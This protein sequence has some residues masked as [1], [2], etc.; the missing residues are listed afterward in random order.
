MKQRLFLL[1]GV[2]AVMA[3]SNTVVPV[4]PLLA[5]GTALQGAVYS[6]YFF[7]AMLTV[8]PAGILSDY[9]GR[10]L[11]L[12]AGLALTF[13]S[14]VLMLVVSDPAALIAI[15]FVE[16]IAAGLFV[17]AAMSW[18]NLQPDRER[19][20]GNFIAALNLGLVSGLV[21]AGW[22]AAPAG[23]LGGV[24]AFTAFTAVPLLM[25]AFVGEAV[26]PKRERGDP[27]GVGKDFFWLYLS[28]IVL[29]G[30]TGAV[31]AI[32]PDFT[33]ESAATLGLQ[34]GLMNVATIVTSLAASRLRLAPIP[35]IRVSAVLMAAAV[36]LLFFTPAAFMLIGGIAGVV[37]IAQINYLAT[38]P[39]RQG[40]I[41]GIFN[42]SSYGG[43]TL[44]PFMAGVVAENQGFSA[45]FALIAILAALMA[46]TIGQCR[47]RPEP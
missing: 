32:Y 15:R 23:M 5:E 8:I 34:L 7:G 2:F 30:A 11:L 20:S 12:R 31:S 28:T 4:L 38:D 37:M 35:T 18:I 3:L 40:T 10:V 29:V 17:P 14:G 1:L 42:A 19:M 16:G 21:V 6:A 22:L 44:L 13:V 46:V 27:G 26:G 45:A 41:M 9:I 36:L 33:G 43:M 39:E 47:C 25:S 24:M